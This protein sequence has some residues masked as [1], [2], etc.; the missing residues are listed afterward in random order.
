MKISPLDRAI[1]MNIARQMNAIE[2]DAE[3]K[4]KE[5]DKAA[6]ADQNRS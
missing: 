3:K 1:E 5:N 2:Q 6:E 4:Q